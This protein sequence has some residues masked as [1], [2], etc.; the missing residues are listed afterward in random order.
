MKSN[1]TRTFNGK[2]DNFVSKEEST[3]EKKMLRAYLRG[4][5]HFQNGWINIRMGI[6]KQYKVEQTYRSL[7]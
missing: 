6:P 7:G 3:H 4:D 1:I 5:T 2:L